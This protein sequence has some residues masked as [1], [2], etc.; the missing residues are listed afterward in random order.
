MAIALNISGNRGFPIGMPSKK[1]PREQAKPD[2]ACAI[3]NQEELE[4]HELDLLAEI[5]DGSVATT[6]GGMANLRLWRQERAMETLR[7]HK[8]AASP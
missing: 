7:K 6:N 2:P 5:H 4:R 1:R 3:L 8:G